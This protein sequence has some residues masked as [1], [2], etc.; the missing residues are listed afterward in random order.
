MSNKEDKKIHMDPKEVAEIFR[1]LD[2]YRAEEE[3]IDYIASKALRT[4]DNGKSN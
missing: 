3:A 1:G 4:K 2:T